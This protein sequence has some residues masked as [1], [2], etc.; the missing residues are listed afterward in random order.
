[1]D[2]FDSILAELSPED[3]A[4]L[5]QEAKDD[6][7][8]R[9]DLRHLLDSNQLGLYEEFNSSTFKRFVLECARRLGKSFLC[10]VIAIVV[11]LRKERARVVYG[12]PTIKEALEIVI[13]I[14]EQIAESAPDDCRPTYNGQKGCFE[15]PNGSRI[16]VFGCDDKRKAN[17]GRGPE[18]DL[19]IID[20]AGFIE[21]LGYVLHAVVNPQTLTTGGRVLLASTPSDEPDHDFTKIAE[22]AE[23]NGNYATRTIDDN[24]RLTQEQIDEYVANDAADLGMTVEEYK[25]SDVYQREHLARRVVDRTMVAIAEEW[26][27]VRE[28]CFVEVERPEFFDG[29]Q[30]IDYGGVDPHA[31]LLG[32]YHFE[33][34]WIVVEDELLLREGQTTAEIAEEVKKKEL[35]LWGTDTYAGTLRGLPD[36]KPEELPDW[37]K[38][39]LKDKAPHQPYLRICDNDVQLAKDLALLH[40]LAYLPTR[41]DEK[42][43]MVNEARIL[44]RQ[45]RLKVHPR[46]RNL[47]RHLRTTMWSNHRQTE[48]RRK[49]GEH[50]DLVDCLVYWVRNLRRHKDPRPALHG[51]D[52]ANTHIREQR[53]PNPWAKALGVKR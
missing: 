29:Y 28:E 39:K 6:C 18:A 3:R 33:K 51:V 50:G 48:F 8:R 22:I 4:A 38:G 35:A 20:E 16:V 34:D 44:V 11:A 41:K 19:I 31:V 15:F 37:L 26:N 43:L 21:I 7:W 36:W 47:D 1:M 23:S 17:R 9:G 13:P 40:G 30:I 45:G 24:P 10:C 52:R 46:C 14:I 12:A 32:Y 27:A 5:I 49:G 42:R 53:K 25:R 2:E